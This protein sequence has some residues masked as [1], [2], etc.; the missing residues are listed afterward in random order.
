MK[1]SQRMCT[2][3]AQWPRRIPGCERRVVWSELSFE[4]CSGFPLLYGTDARFEK[5]RLVPL[6][7]LRRLV[8]MTIGH[9]Y[10]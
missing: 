8:V 7:I 3:P 10:R 9:L 6:R 1:Y 5:L 2:F 4:V